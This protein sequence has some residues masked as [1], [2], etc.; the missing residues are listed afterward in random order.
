MT[1]HNFDEIIDRRGSNSFK[2]D[3]FSKEA[4]PMWVADM[5]FKVPAPITSALHQAVDHAV[6]GYS[7]ESKELRNNVVT[8]MKKLYGWEID[9]SWI[10]TTTGLVSAFFAAADLLCQDQ[11]GYLIQTPVYMPFNQL[12]DAF[13][14]TRQEN[15]LLPV[16]TGNKINYQFDAGNFSAAF[17]TGGVRTKMFLLCNPHN[18]VG[19]CYS[20]DELAIMAEKCL[21]NEAIIVSD[22]I[23]SELLLDGNKHIPIATLSK[24]I[25]NNTITLVSPS[26]TFNVAGLF[27]GFA[28]IANEDLRKKYKKTVERMTLHVSGLSLVAA[29]AAFSGECDEWLGDLN[30]YLTLNRNHLV[31]RLTADLPELITTVPQA[32]YLGWLGFGEPIE[33][34]KLTGEPNEYLYKRGHIVLN[35]GAAFGPGGEKFARINFGC[36]RSLLDDGI[37]RIMDALK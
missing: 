3:L 16:I 8:R 21:E 31:S 27:C 30:T 35:N 19:K 10:V 34:G 18:P 17:H 11:G 28:I 13:G 6:F 24:E 14:I 1:I 15:A 9:E 5:D 32:T 25:E 23:H 12:Q 4:L 2:W 33:N 20:R 36:P 7:M 26:K 22:E 29:Q 37:D